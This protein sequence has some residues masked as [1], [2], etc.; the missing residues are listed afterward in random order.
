MTRIPVFFMFFFSSFCLTRIP[1]LVSLWN[2]LSDHVFDGVELAGF[3]SR[4]NAFLLAK[5]LVHFLSPAVFP[6]SSLILWV[7][8]VGLGTDRTDRVLI[9]SSLLALHCQPF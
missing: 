9:A 5:Q 1:L 2:D 4:A 6:F 3:K 7:G 8:V